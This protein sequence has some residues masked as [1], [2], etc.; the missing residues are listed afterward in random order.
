M[1]FVSLNCV[2]LRVTWYRESDANSLRA[3][4]TPEHHPLCE[5]SAG[6][7]ALVE[8][9]ITQRS[10]DAIRESESMCATCQTRVAVIA[11]NGLVFTNSGLERMFAL[12]VE[13]PA[14]E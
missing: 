2:A 5:V 12:L 4:T 1:S 7:L 13:A 6:D 11:A 14:D 8:Y 3:A 10:L 9:G